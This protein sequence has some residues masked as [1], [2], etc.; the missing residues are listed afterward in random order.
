MV[1]RLVSFSFTGTA[2]SHNVLNSF[3]NNKHYVYLFTYSHDQC[4]ANEGHYF[5]ARISSKIIYTL[6]CYLTVW[7]LR[8]S[9]YFSFPWSRVRKNIA[10]LGGF[11]AFRFCPSGTKT[12]IIIIFVVVGRY[13][14]VGIATRYRLD[15]P[16]I[17]SRWGRDFPHLSRPALGPTQPPVQWVPGLSWG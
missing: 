3:L 7:I 5:P 9:M 6:R 13:S 14:S 15:G 4:S 11:L 16:G 1:P 2:L 10:V 12:I 8:E 17:E